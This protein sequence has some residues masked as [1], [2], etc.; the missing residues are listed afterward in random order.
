MIVETADERY[1]RNTN[2]VEGL[3]LTQAL[4]RRELI[5]P[6]KFSWTQPDVLRN[7][8]PCGSADNIF[9]KK[10]W[11]EFVRGSGVILR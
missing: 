6:H 5:V 1:R 9:L 7:L 10:S 2:F 11:R 4:S 3:A 8:L